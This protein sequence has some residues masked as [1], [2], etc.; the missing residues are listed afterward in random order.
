MANPD[1]QILETELGPMISRSRT[2]VYDVMEM[3]NKGYDLLSLCTIHNL[4]PVQV[5][6]A[7]EYIEQHRKTLEPEL[8]ELLKKR[9]EREQYYRLLAAERQ[10]MIAQKPM[11]PKRAAFYVQRERNRRLR[12][13]RKSNGTNHS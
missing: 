9:A 2:S 6:I 7:L 5:M 8:K 3:Q 12:E 10:K 1:Y 13:E 4:N 11:T